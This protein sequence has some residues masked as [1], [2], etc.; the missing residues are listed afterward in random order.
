MGF[1]LSWVRSSGKGYS[2][3]SGTL[4]RAWVAYRS[5]FALT[6]GV[7]SP[8]DSLHTYGFLTYVGSLLSLRI[9]S[10]YRLVFT[11]GFLPSKARYGIRDYF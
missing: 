8:F 5:R 9:S 2:E 11:L 3:Y 6:Q 1:S 10:G 7:S 4:G